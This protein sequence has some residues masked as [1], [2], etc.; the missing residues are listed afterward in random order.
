M[1]CSGCLNT[2]NRNSIVE[3]T[4]QREGVEGR[5]GREKGRD[6]ERE[7]KGKGEGEWQKLTEEEGKEEEGKAVSKFKSGLIIKSEWVSNKV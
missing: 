7:W 2:C 3:E 4:R 6:R 1:N 5:G